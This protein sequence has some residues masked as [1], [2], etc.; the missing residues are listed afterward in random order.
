MRISLFTIKV[1]AFWFIQGTQGRT[2]M[3]Y[4]GEKLSHQGG[5]EVH[6]GD[7]K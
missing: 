3:D 6:Q 4:W 1:G 5:C 2:N 7:D